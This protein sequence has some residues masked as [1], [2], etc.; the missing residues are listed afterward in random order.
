MFDNK[1]SRLITSEEGKPENIICSHNLL[2]I[3]SLKNI[4][5]P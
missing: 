5:N 4:I 2:S 3:E 1:G